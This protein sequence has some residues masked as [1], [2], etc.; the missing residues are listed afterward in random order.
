MRYKT[1]NVL[2]GDTVQTIAQ[3]T[4]GTMFAWTDIVAYN[5]LRYPYISDEYLGPHVATI[6][7][8][9]IIPIEVTDD[10][11]RNVVLKKQDVDVIASYALGRDLALVDPIDDALE[12]RGT[13]D[14]LVNLQDNRGDLKTKY[15]H[16]NLI[17]AILLRMNTKKGTMPLHPEYGNNFSDLLGQRL[18]YDLLNKFEVMIR[19]TINEEP[20]VAD[21]GVELEVAKNNVILIKLH[22]NPIDTEE[23][24]N[25]V[26]SMDNDGTVL[27]K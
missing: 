2:Q 7:D 11:L 6:G 1:Y 13:T 22:V 10:D 8:E 26:I 9:L 5:K 21:A 24:L 20:R 3:T 19:K 18:T 12:T 15:G 17:Q 16:D 27:L 4:L 14:E 23:Q 25:I